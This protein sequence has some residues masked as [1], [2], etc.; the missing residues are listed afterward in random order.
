LLVPDGAKEAA[1]HGVKA[2]RSKSG[3][4]CFPRRRDAICARL[5]HVTSWVR[6]ANRTVAVRSILPQLLIELGS[7]RPPGCSWVL[8]RWRPK[9]VAAQNVTSEV[10]AFGHRDFCGAS[11]PDRALRFARCR[12]LPGGHADSPFLKVVDLTITSPNTT[13]SHPARGSLSR[14]RNAWSATRFSAKN[15]TP[16]T[17]QAAAGKFRS[18]RH[19]NIGFVSQQRGS[20]F[21]PLLIG[22]VAQ[23]NPW[24]ATVLVDDSTLAPGGYG[25]RY[26][27]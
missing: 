25:H 12:W 16:A 8:A 24:P 20:R 18:I 4:F 9:R 17:V 23:A 3:F 5:S 7:L 22:R 1:G 10:A 26:A 19:I 2:K 6:F 21:S 11:A 14:R 15:T 13:D 27:K